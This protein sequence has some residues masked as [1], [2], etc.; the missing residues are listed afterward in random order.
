MQ[1]AY[2]YVFGLTCHEL[3]TA[4]LIITIALVELW[5]NQTFQNLLPCP[6]YEKCEDLNHTQ[7]L[8]LA[9]DPFRHLF[10]QKESIGFDFLYCAFL[11]VQVWL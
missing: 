2:C 11:L 3:S 9:D 4:A 7:F 5:C 8:H 1:G 6:M 10:L